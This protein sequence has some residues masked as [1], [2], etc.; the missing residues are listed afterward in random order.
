M[1]K[2]LSSKESDTKKRVLS[3]SFFC[4]FSANFLGC[5]DLIPASQKEDFFSQLALGQAYFDSGDFNQALKHAKLAYELNPKSEEAANSLGYIYLGLAGADP[6][7]IVTRLLSTGDGQAST[8]LKGANVLSTLK[9]VFGVTQAEYRSLGIFDTTVPS[10]PVILPSCAS[11]ARASVANLIYVNLAMKTVCTFVS[12]RILQQSDPRDLCPS[13]PLSQHSASTHLLWALA[14][15]FEAVTFYAVINYSTTTSS[16][17]N[18]ELRVDS[19]QKTSDLQN[20]ANIPVFV[21]ET[22]SIANLISR[23]MPVSQ[24]C[25]PHDVQTQMTALLL[26]LVAV[27]RAFASMSGLPPSLIAPIQKATAQITEIESKLSGSRAQT[28]Q[29]QSLRADF[30]ANLSKALTA[31][32]ASAKAG[33]FTTAERNQVCSSMQIIQTTSAKL[34]TLCN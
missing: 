30:T 29:E 26:D 1:Q 20:P 15:L 4:L 13:N 19:L 8:Q 3:L 16:Q 17:S 28:A 11:T 9:D 31:Q 7:S 21:A 24:I 2:Q 12:P 27:E 23:I 6:Y 18:L 32:I 14:H 10:L 22:R 25:S 5:G 33:S 34:P